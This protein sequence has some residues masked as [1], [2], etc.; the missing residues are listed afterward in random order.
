[1]RAPFIVFEGSVFWKRV[2]ARGGS[3]DRFEEQAFH[4]KVVR[5]YHDFG[6]DV[7]LDDGMVKMLDGEVDAE[8]VEAAVWA[9]LERG[10]PSAAWARCARHQEVVL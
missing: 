10:V 5:A 7:A 2:L 1:M 6:W 9:D 4:Q 3:P 8:A